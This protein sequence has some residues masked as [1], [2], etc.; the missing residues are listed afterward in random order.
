M[1]DWK[2]LVKPS[3]K[4]AGAA[5]ISNSQKVAT[6]MDAALKTFGETKGEGKRQV[7]T[8]S[9]DVIT[10]SVRFGNS[11]IELLDGV[12]K[13]DVSAKDFKAAYE[14]IKASVLAGDFD[15]KLEAI[16]AS[17]ARTPAPAP[18]KRKYTKRS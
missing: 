15:A 3:L 14:G 9:G 7:I 8:Q 10:F 5:K 6:Q 2:T 13:L 11:P 17:R 1:A 18:T 4:K 12:T 16:A